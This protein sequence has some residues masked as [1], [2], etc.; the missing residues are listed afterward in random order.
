MFRIHFTADDL[1]RVRLTRGW[2]PLVETHLSLVRLGRRDPR[3][4]LGGWSARAGRTSPG[5]AHPCAPLLDDGWLDLLTVTGPVGSLEEGLTALLAVRPEQFRAELAA[6]AA[7]GGWH[8]DRLRRLATAGDPAGNRTDRRRLVTFLRD[9][10]RVAVAPYWSRIQ[11]RLNAEYSVLAQVLSAQGVEGLLAQ[12]APFAHWRSPVLQ[13]GHGPTANDIRLDGRGLTLVPSLFFDS[14][15][16]V[17]INGMD[18]QAP[19]VLLLPATRGPGDLAGVLVD[20]SAADRLTALVNLLGRTRAYAL[21]S[22]AADPC[23]TGELA[24]RLAIS[25]AS[26]SEH[27]TVLRDAGLVTTTRQGRAVRHH[28]TTMGERLLTGSLGPPLGPDQSAP[29]AGAALAG[30][31]AR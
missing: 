29:G 14:G 26:A 15:P 17:W 18:D 9:H 20:P 25:A 4:A 8:G 16:A 28:L 1:A 3:D 5:L 24:R 31:M 2:G 13:V 23:T 22:I 6:A 19:V 27:A 21:D 30:A 11:A 12:L 7:A 10:H